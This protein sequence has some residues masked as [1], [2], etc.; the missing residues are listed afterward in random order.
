MRSSAA[1][2]GRVMARPECR[3]AFPEGSWTAGL[4]E[5]AQLVPLHP[6]LD[7]DYAEHLGGPE[8]DRSSPFSAV[9][10][11][12]AEKHVSPFQV[13]VDQSQK[14]I[15]VSSIHP[16]FEIVGLRCSQQEDDGPLVVSFMVSAPP[17]V[18]TVLHHAGRHFLLDGT[19]RVYRLMRAGFSH[20]PCIV[21]DAPGLAQLAS[22][23]P[24]VFPPS[25]LM[26]PRPPLFPD[27]ADPALGLTAPL[28]AMRR[29]I[30]LRPDEYLVAT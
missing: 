20:V 17:P 3:S 27:F 16:A 2:I 5:I 15:T 12:F 4:V 18:V 19:H 30:R 10:L 9:R 14:S 29:V 22:R 25:L 13:G 26:A 11:C 7:I 1:E 23:V 21:R 28:R 24:Q 6:N 8:L